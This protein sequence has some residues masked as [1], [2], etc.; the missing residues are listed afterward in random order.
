MKLA[1]LERLKGSQCDWGEENRWWDWK[2]RQGAAQQNIVGYV[3][4]F[5]FHVSDTEGRR[6]AWSTLNQVFGC[7]FSGYHIHHHSSGGAPMKFLFSCLYL[8]IECLNT[9]FSYIQWVYE[10]LLCWLP[11]WWVLQF[12]FFLT[13]KRT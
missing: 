9:P 3:M 7:K 2:E 6:M 8:L 13:F 10:C 4:E 11:Y 12:F 5:E 1:E